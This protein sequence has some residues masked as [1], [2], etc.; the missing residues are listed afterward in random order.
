MSGGASSLPQIGFPFF[1]DHCFRLL[2]S[3]LLQGDQA[4]REKTKVTSDLQ[5]DILIEQRV[6]NDG[7]SMLLAYVLWIFLGSLGA[8]RFYLGR[9]GSAVIMLIL[10]IA[11]WALTAVGVGL[12]LLAI[13]G[14]WLLIDLFLIPGMISRHKDEMRRRLAVELPGS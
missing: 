8:H 2:S 11:G 12:G 13:L 7:K 9:T 14:L 4:R 10:L 6:A 5:R 1:V 3:F